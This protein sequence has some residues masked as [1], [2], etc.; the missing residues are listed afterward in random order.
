MWT[1]VQDPDKDW[2]IDDG[3]YFAKE[4][5]LNSDGSDMS[6]MQARQMV[7]DSV[8]DG[9]FKKPPEVK[10]NCVRVQ[11]DA[12][13]RVD[14]PVYRRIALA[15]GTDEPTLQYERASDEWRRSDA[16][17]VTKWFQGE[18]KSQSP[19][20][21]NGRQL[22]RVTREIKKYARS[23]RGWKKQILGGF[24]ITKLV[25][26]SYRPDA[27]R[28]DKALHNT[29]K[30]IRDRLT[31]NLVVNHP[32]TPGETITKGAADSKA[33]FLRDRL[34]EAL[35]TLADLFEPSCTREKALRCWDRVFNTDY[36]SKRCEKSVD[37]ESASRAPGILSYG[38]LKKLGESEEARAAVRK[39]GGG[40]Y[41]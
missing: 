2:D 13:Y 32:T 41:A 7:R 5:L 22:R 28:E 1:M 23:R 19:D 4:A 21:T 11:Y 25:T 24:G 14:I 26:E 18:N 29:M 34:S 3:Y 6:P 35:E 10:P 33:V 8:D 31:W 39:E 9:S 38:L 16:R 12:G 30:A 40:R 37:E 36:F 15:N 17:D 27:D 20:E